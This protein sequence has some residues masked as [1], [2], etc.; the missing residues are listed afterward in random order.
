MEADHQYQSGE[1]YVSASGRIGDVQHA[2]L[3]TQL[4]GLRV[5]NKIVMDELQTNNCRKKVG[6]V[7]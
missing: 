7:N 4:P 1:G 6:S 2:G 5:T 3:E